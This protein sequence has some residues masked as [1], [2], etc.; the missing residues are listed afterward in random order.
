MNIPNIYLFNKSKE[1]SNTIYKVRIKK[2]K[3]IILAVFALISLAPFYGSAQEWGGEKPNGFWDHWAVN[4]NLGFTSYF[5]DLSYYDSDIMGKLSSESGPAFGLLVT[6]YFDKKFG[7]SGQLLYGSL[8]GGDNK[9]RSFETNLVEYNIQARLDFMRIILPHRN[10]KFGLEGFAGLGQMWFKSTQYNFKEDQPTSN[11]HK[12]EV[13][14]FVYFAGLGI[15][16]HVSESIAI[17]SSISLRQLQNDRLDNLV[18]NENNDY[19][20]YFNIGITYYFDSKNSR[21]LKNKARLAHSGN[22]SR[23][24]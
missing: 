2:K 22:R 24:K 10:P 18:K 17:T 8:K 11:T 19:Y 6:K 23:R 21:P 12:S 9:T 16:Y 5:G 20:S 3:Y 15:H 7:I 13:P 1:T 14:E 4:A